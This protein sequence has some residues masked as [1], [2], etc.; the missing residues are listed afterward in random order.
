MHHAELSNIFAKCRPLP[1]TI[2]VVFEPGSGV[3]QIERLS[4]PY[5]IPKKLGE[6][7]QIQT[8]RTHASKYPTCIDEYISCIR[9][10]PLAAFAESSITATDHPSAAGF[11]GEDAKIVGEVADACKEEEEGADA[12]GAFPAVIEEQLRHTRTEVEDCA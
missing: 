6:N 11:V 4:L 8:Q 12:V 9:S 1:L 10:P 5:P 3:F 2:F 7:H